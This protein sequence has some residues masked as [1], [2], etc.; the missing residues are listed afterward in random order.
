MVFPVVSFPLMSATEQA[1]LRRSY[2]RRDG[3]TAQLTV[4]MTE[5]M[6]SDVEREAAADGVSAADVVRMALTEYLPKLPGAPPDA[7]RTRRPD[8]V[9]APASEES[10]L[11]RLR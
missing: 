11:W 7:R 5:R 1:P 9:T 10:I 2:R 3:L 4:A 8:G 6:R